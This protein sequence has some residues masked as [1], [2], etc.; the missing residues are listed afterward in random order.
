MS[1]MFSFIKQSRKQS[2]EVQGL[3]LSDLDAEGMDPEVNKVVII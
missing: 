3:Y 1:N 2:T